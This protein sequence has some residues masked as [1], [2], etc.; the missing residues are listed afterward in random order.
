[1][2]STSSF[3]QPVGYEEDY[4]LWAEEQATLLVKHNFPALDIENLVEELRTMGRSE[5]RSIQHRLTVLVS[6]LLKCLVQP[7]HKSAHWSATLL[8]QRTRIA[9]LLH[10]SPSL[11]QHVAKD[12][13]NNY[14]LAVKQ[15]A[16]DTHLPT[17]SFPAANPF[18]VEQILD[19]DYEP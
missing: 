5:R 3:E 17:S 4:A 7:D 15:A 6:H 12:I 2:L 13:V 19:P 1:M 9:G 11:R 8:E 16:A 14:A 10:D 18:T